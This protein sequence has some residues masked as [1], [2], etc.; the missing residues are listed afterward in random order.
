MRERAILLLT[1]HIDQ[2]F[3]KRKTNNPKLALLS[4]TMLVLA[5]SSYLEKKNSQNYEYSHRLFRN[6]LS[7]NNN[8][9]N[10]F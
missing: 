8:V 1:G 9:R 2:N 6:S 3:S 5:L 7:K 10:E 4:T